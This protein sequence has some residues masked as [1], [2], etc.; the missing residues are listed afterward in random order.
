MPTWE[1]INLFYL[2]FAVISIPMV[3]GFSMEAGK[4]IYNLVRKRP[5]PDVLRK[6]LVEM[7]EKN[8]RDCLG[9]DHI[10]TDIDD[11]KKDTQ[12]MATQQS[13]MRQVRLPGIEKTLVELK[14]D[15]RHMSSNV[16]EIKTQIEKLFNLWNEVKLR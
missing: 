11:L 12:F 13:T 6:E 15:V 4:D 16:D 8:R 7:C 9:R 1:Q 3:M 14:S 2:V 5:T 10:L